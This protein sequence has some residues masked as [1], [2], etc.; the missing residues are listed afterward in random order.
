MP[1]RS[2]IDNALYTPDRFVPAIKRLGGGRIARAGDGSIYAL[3]GAGAIVVRLDRPTGQAIA[4]RIPRADDGAPAALAI[5]AAFATDPVIARLRAR[6]ASPIAGG[7]SVIPHGIIVTEGGQEHSHP[8]IAMEWLGD[9]NLADAVRSMVETNDIVRLSQIGTQW[10]RLMLALAEERFTHGDLS[11]E[12][13]VLRRGDA[14]AIVDYDTAAWPNSPRGGIGNRER[15][16]RHPSGETPFVVERRDDFAALAILVSLRALALEPGLLQPEGAPDEGLVFTAADFAEPARSERFHR[17]SRMDDPETVALAAI[18]SEACRMPA[19]QVP[20]FEEAIRV[21]RSVA[22]RI[23]RSESEQERRPATEEP[24]ERSAP[25]RLDAQERQARLTRLNAMLLRGSDRDALDYWEASGLA[26]DAQAKAS[27]GRLVDA[28]R[29]RLANLDRPKPTTTPAP[30][31][32]KPEETADQRRRAGWR[33]I[34]TGA[35]MARLEAA[36]ANRDHATVLREWPDIRDTPDASRYAAIVHQFA[37]EYWANAI[38]HASR[39]GNA[40]AVLEAVGQADAA[41]VAIPHALRPLIREAEQRA[42]TD[43]FNTMEE[44]AT[45]ANSHPELAHALERDDDRVVAAVIE[46]SEREDFSD[47]PDPI[48][49]RI[50]ISLR[51]VD[52]ATN[53]RKALR[54]RRINQLGD[55]LLQPVPGADRLLSPTERARIARIRERGEA[56]IAVNQALSARN[57]RAFIQAMRRMELAGA[58]L[59]PDLDTRAFTEALE[60]ITRVTALRRAVTTPGE[61][62]PRTVARLVPAAVMGGVE[63]EVVERLVNVEDVDRELVRLGHLARIREVIAG[64]DPDAIVAAALPDNH[65]VLRSLTREERAAVEAAAKNARPLPG[66]R[67]P[68]VIPGEA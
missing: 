67:K 24:L 48:R 2:T 60:R 39:T 38:R 51:R 61:H 58:P 25:K 10:Q 27:S 17:I 1:S 36:I 14:I 56:Q 65:D 52:W 9:F 12:N 21:A 30:A 50:E 18:L 11:P 59:P 42:G 43:A 55:L 66:A 47:L 5:H 62:D 35:S 40:E 33:V 63:W 45:W 22:G 20:P 44:T 26:E 46:H 3:S 54:A 32:P 64:G 8:V 31:P 68:R 57:D 23:R 29:D 41:G 53:V 7:V 19:E 28:A 13:A 6:S 15:A 16:Y 4:L 37:T 49:G 34:S